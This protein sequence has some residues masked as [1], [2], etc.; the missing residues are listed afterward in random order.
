DQIGRDLD[1]I[2]LV[3][4]RL[5][6]ANRKPAGI[7]ADDPVVKAL[8]PGLAFGN[9]LRLEA[10]V[11]VAWHGQIDRPVIA[12]HS[13]AR[14]AVPAGAGAPARWIAL[15]VSQSLGQLCSQRPLHQAP[16]QLV[17]QP[18]LPPPNARAA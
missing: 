4:M 11:T 18:L 1:A 6:L 10:A 2:E 14:I 16:F 17:K 13:F 9:N 5:D 15:L 3:Q 12:D 7:E 8:D